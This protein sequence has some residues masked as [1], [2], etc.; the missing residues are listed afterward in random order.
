MRAR[1]DSAII[2]A[3]YSSEVSGVNRFRHFH[4]PI[5]LSDRQKNKSDMSSLYENLPLLEKKIKKNSRVL[6][7]IAKPCQEC[8]ETSQKVSNSHLPCLILHPK[9]KHISRDKIAVASD[10]NSY[11]YTYKIKSTTKKLHSSSNIIL[12]EDSFGSS[13]T[14]PNASDYESGISKSSSF[15]NNSSLLSPNSIFTSMEKNSYKL[16]DNSTNS[17]L[18]SKVSKPDGLL[19]VSN[20]RNIPTNQSFLPA[21]NNG[22]I[23]RRL[24]LLSN[25]LS[26][27]NNEG[28]SIDKAQS[29]PLLT[30]QSKRKLKNLKN[31]MK[32]F[33]SD[34]LTAIND[35]K[36][37]QFERDDNI[38]NYK[39]KK[40]NL[41]EIGT[42][43]D[44][45]RF[46]KD[47]NGLKK[48]KKQ[49]K[50]NMSMTTSD[51]GIQTEV[52]SIIQ[53]T[54]ASQTSL[55]PPQDNHF[56]TD[57][58]YA[59]EYYQ[60]DLFNEFTKALSETI[61]CDSSKNLAH[62]ILASIK[63]KGEAWKYAKKF[64]STIL[65]PQSVS[66]AN[67]AQYNNKM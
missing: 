12:S 34:N 27:T 8:S 13:R 52:S 39:M 57:V 65:I 48:K 2:R 47:K 25:N 53:I 60:L 18:Y 9:N 58:D 51:S 43:T 56:K 17:S 4:T 28:L 62:N 33:S 40:K 63:E 15:S 32:S 41:V 66:L 59:D 29:K 64:V 46:K 61:D 49:S 3:R 19:K 36:D 10:I 21:S 5:I 26:Y 14:L 42:Q 44:K 67:K 38:V 22:V 30:K 54:K 20:I 1:S 35:I 31:D 6:L 50:T 11:D 45:V 24:N 55:N 7:E 37:Y 23:P 16:F